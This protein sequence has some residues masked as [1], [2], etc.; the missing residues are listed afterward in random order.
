MRKIIEL[1]AIDVIKASS[2]LGAAIVATHIIFL[3][4]IFGFNEQEFY[5]LDYHFHLDGEFNIPSF[6]SSM[7][8]LYSSILLLNAY[9]TTRSR[10]PDLYWIVLSVIFVYLAADEFFSFHER[11]ILPIRSYLDLEG[12][13]YFSW[14]LVGAVFVA[15]VFFSALPFLYRLPKNIALQFCLAGFIYISGVL[16]VEMIGS[17]EAF[18][19]GQINGWVSTKERGLTYAIIVTIEESL[20]IFG[21]LFF[22][23]TLMQYWKKENYKQTKIKNDELF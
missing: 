7:I 23:Y 5:G 1:F 6:Y 19:S 12:Y 9:Y 15:V 11:L 17:N 20:E 10:S 18:Q 2:L 8:L 16:G 3:V 21:V 22:N 13:F 14:I 4:L